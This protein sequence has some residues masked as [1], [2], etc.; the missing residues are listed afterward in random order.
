MSNSTLNKAPPTTVK[1]AA[2]LML[3]PLADF[4]TRPAAVVKPKPVALFSS[5]ADLETECMPPAPR[6]SLLLPHVAATSRVCTH[7]SEKR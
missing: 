4:G 7:A 1:K 2:A 3:N 5:A 6:T